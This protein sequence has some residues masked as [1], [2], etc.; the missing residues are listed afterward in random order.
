MTPSEALTFVRDHGVVLE[1]ANGPVPS[2]ASTIAG[3]TIAGSWW[4]HPRSH[5]IFASTRVLRESKDVLVCRLVNGKV[6]FVH[7]E[8]WPALVRCADHFPAEHLAQIEEHH[9]QKGHHI[10]KSVP[11][12]DWVPAEVLRT[13]ETLSE[14]DALRILGSWAK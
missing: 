6:T 14:D 2:L 8:R 13:S 5:E 7:S 3:E 1:S 11:F 10:T 9:T 4:G 12:P